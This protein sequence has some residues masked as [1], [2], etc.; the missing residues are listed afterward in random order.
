M[1]GDRNPD[2]PRPSSMMEAQHM[3][4][5]LMGRLARREVDEEEL[6]HIEEHLGSCSVCAQKASDRSR[7]ALSQLRDYFFIEAPAPLEHPD[8]AELARYARRALDPAATELVEAHLDECAADC[9]T[10]IDG[11]RRQRRVRTRR[12]W[13]AAA[14]A[15]ILIAV[16]LTLVTRRPHP[17]TPPPVAKQKPAK[18]RVQPRSPESVQIAAAY[19][20]PEWNALVGKATETGRV[21]LPGDLAELR[22]RVDIIRG[23]GDEAARVS[24]AGVVIDDVRPRFHWPSREGATYMVFVFDGKHEIARST[25]LSST[26]W[27]APTDLPRGRTLTWQVE[28]TRGDE[29]ETIPHPPAPHARFRIISERDRQN[30]SRAREQYPG[31]DLLLGVLYAR[32]G[33]L[34]D[35]KASLRR[36]AERNPVAQRL[37]ES[38]PKG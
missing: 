19:S 29:V 12:M 38:L 4:D 21:P 35:A 13:I 36:A 1:N 27:T 25:Q 2:A 24:P 37:L 30:L 8:R 6:R 20:D 32:A 14:A 16:I 33:M 9:A 17:G 23:S 26:R 28:A 22:G 31:D 10:I 11:I 15:A 34:D 7:A 5:A 18:E 3:D